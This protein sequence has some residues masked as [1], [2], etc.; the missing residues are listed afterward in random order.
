MHSFAYVDPIL[1]HV[2]PMPDVTVQDYLDITNI[3]QSAPGLPV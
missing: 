3:K 1:H 2:Y